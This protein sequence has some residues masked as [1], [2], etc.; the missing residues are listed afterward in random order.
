MYAHHLVLMNLLMC[1]HLSIHEGHHHLLVV[2]IIERVELWP[3]Q[4]PCCLA[5]STAPK[6]W[7]YY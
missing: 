6:L 2:F 7:K 3:H 4:Y 5:L 1:E